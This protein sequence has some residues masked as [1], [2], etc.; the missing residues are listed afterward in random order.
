[1]SRKEEWRKIL[2][3][4]VQ[5]W[6]ALPWQELVFRLQDIQCYEVKS[7]AKTYQVEVELL[8]NTDTYVHI[9]VAVDDGT[10]PASMMPLTETFIR[11]KLPSSG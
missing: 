11:E 9:L 10:L 5:R 3:P 4:E 6:S 2:D 7:D 8:E 1:M